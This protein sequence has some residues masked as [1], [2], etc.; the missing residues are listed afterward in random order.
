MK[1]D[2]ILEAMEERLEAK[3]GVV[4]TDNIL[5][6]KSEMLD[7]IQD[8]RTAFPQSL[9]HANM[10]Y[11]DREKI[12]ADA[13]LRASEAIKK[14]EIKAQDIIAEANQRAAELIETHE[15]TRKA[16]INAED[17]LINAKS[18][19]KNI[20]EDARAV[21]KGIQDDTFDFVEEKIA[22][23]ENTFSNAKYNFEYLKNDFY[24]QGGSLFSALEQNMSKEYEAVVGN[25]K[26]FLDYRNSLE[27]K[28]KQELIQA[29]MESQE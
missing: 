1:I 25:R 18:E 2:S 14:A 4:F 27:E 9:S 15:I 24:K 11:E 20:I 21:S 8:I 16:K 19:A 7:Y 22:K 17:I 26:A 29:N 13:E 10:I 12:M 5:V 3:G 23:L 28:Y 6:K